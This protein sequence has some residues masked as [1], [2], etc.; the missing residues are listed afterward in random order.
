MDFMENIQLQVILNRDTF[1]VDN[2]GADN[3]Y[4][5]NDKGIYTFKRLK[6]K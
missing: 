5:E 6:E 3:L 2:L 4:L 1:D